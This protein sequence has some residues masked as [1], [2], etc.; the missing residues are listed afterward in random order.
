MIPNAASVFKTFIINI[1]CHS[2]V[3]AISGVQTIRFKNELIR[4]ITIKL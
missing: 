1:Y 3:K 2:V 4:N